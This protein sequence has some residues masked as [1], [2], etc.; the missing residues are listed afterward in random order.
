M[1]HC[2]AEEVIDDV[3]EEL[4]KLNI[5]SEYRAS[6]AWMSTA[7]LDIYVRNVDTGE[8]I[9]Y[10]NKDSEDGHTYLDGNPLGRHTNWKWF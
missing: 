2:E 5:T 6:L 3:A 7:D 4:E 8:T 1:S 10:G 9:F